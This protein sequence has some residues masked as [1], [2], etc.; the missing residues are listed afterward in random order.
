M[1]LVPVYCRASAPRPGA[2]FISTSAVIMPQLFPVWL[3]TRTHPHLTA[4][5]MP[6]KTWACLR[7]QCIPRQFF[8]KKREPARR[9]AIG[10]LLGHCALPSGKAP[11][12]ATFSARA[13]RSTPD[14]A[15]SGSHNPQTEPCAAAKHRDA[16]ADPVDAMRLACEA[17]KP[18]APAK[19]SMLDSGPSTLGGS[20]ASMNGG[21]VYWPLTRARLERPR[22]SKP[23][24]QLGGSSAHNHGV[25]GASMS[26]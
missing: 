19:R 25:S 16:A 14:H 13:P 22:T 12:A 4:K 18:P 2:E 1:R 7:R 15:F 6:V 3:G 8:E 9:L 17:T 20:P 10:P 23:A 21:G 11:R 24:R 26:T 5:S